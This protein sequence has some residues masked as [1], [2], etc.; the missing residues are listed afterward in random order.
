MIKYF[1]SVIF[2][3]SLW[4]IDPPKPPESQIQAI[5]DLIYSQQKRLE[6]Q[7]LLKQKMVTLETQKNLFI[8]GNKS[9]K[10]AQ[11]LVANAK[12]ILNLIEQEHLSY[13][14]SAE[15]IQELTF[16]CSL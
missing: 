8:Q 10:H 4:S 11:A 2:T 15:Y 6:L 9:Q 3:S 7:K 1:L 13:L 14:F 16:F 12:E 5:T